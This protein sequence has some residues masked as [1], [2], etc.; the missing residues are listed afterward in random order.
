[1]TF[2]GSARITEDNEYYQKAKDL[3]FQLA[4]EGYT[5]ITG[6]GGG[7]MEAANRGAMELAENQ[8]DSTFAC[9]TSN[10]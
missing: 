5:I 10:P 7:I 8:S 2:F 4:K 6:G 9:H 3:A 1:M